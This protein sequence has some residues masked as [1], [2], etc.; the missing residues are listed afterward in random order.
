MTENEQ[1]TFYFSLNYV[2]INGKH[3][4]IEK[5]IGYV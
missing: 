3:E 4:F 1:R 2:N 5:G